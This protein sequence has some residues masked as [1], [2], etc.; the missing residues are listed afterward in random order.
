[1]QDTDE[2]ELPEE[3][4]FRCSFKPCKEVDEKT[5]G[6]RS[7]LPEIKGMWFCSHLCCNMYKRQQ[8][9]SDSITREVYQDM[10]ERVY[11]NDRAKAGEN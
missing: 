5:R 3:K 8:I 11:K 4:F 2:I 9:I 7:C 6:V 1:M 10:M